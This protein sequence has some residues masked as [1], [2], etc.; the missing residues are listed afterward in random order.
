MSSYCVESFACRGVYFQGICARLYYSGN[1]RQ[2]IQT[3]VHACSHLCELEELC[4]GGG[5]WRCSR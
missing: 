5:K 1:A 3:K 4:H 2:I